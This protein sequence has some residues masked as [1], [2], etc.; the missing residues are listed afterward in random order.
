MISPT[1]EKHTDL[2]LEVDSLTEEC[3]CTLF[4]NQALALR[5]PNYCDP[6]IASKLGMWLASQSN[7]PAYT[8]EVY[9]D[10]IPIQKYYGVYRYGFPY[11]KT[12]GT[13]PNSNIR[14][15]YYQEAIRSIRGLRQACMP[16]LSPIDQVRLE[17]DEIWPTGA[18]V[19]NY[20]G[21][22]MFV[23]IGRI[24]PAADSYILEERPHVDCLPESIYQLDGQF[25]ANVYLQLPKSGGAL[26]VWNV[27]PFSPAEVDA[28]P[29][30]KDWRAELPEP[31]VIRPRVG[32]LVIINT[33][34]LHAVQSF[35]EGT[36]ITVQCFIGYNAHSPLFLW[37]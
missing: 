20:E 9:E 34:R 24:T 23:G 35:S 28:L 13:D 17:L 11:N 12:Y 1:L 22:K 32:E 10:G 14:E 25:S 26:E 5:I 30:D 2:V 8:H 3:L 36:R 33:R 18:Q 29:E 4:K 37:C 7:L 15:Q 21:R 19:A 16:F 6:V 27:P 31:V